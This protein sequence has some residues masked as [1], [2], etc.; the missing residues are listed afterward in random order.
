MPPSWHTNTVTDRRDVAAAVR[1]LLRTVRN[2]I[3][4]H[5]AER[6]TVSYLFSH[7]GTLFINRLTVG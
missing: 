3:H 7:F 5:T 4:K 1:V 2:N 6:Q